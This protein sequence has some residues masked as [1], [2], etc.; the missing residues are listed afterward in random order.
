[1][2]AIKDLDFNYMIFQPNP[3]RDQIFFLDRW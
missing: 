1:M 2:E 3:S